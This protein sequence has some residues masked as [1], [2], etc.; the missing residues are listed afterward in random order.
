MCVSVPVLVVCTCF[1]VSFSM[2]H[3]GV[4]LACDGGSKLFFAAW[5]VVKWV[6]DFTAAEP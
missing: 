3:T 4:I 6:T 2:T 1:W 5:P